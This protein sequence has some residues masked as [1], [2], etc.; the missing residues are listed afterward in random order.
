M[1]KRPRNQSTSLRLSDSTPEPDATAEPLPPLSSFGD[2][3][4]SHA[5]EQEESATLSTASDDD[6]PVSKAKAA[7]RYS[8]ECADAAREFLRAFVR[9]RGGHKEAAAELGVDRITV[10][11]TLSG[12]SQPSLSLLLALRK[13]TRTTLDDLLGLEPL[14]G[15]GSEP[16]PTPEMIARIR[17]LLEDLEKGAK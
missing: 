11:R 9:G 13:A 10:Y 4:T 17:T 2:V 7:H 1:N 8:D 16:P 6:D 5:E 3:A 14:G 12:A 15:R